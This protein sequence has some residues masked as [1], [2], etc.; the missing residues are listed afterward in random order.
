M[1][2]KQ[3]ERTVD[4][5]DDKLL[6]AG[7]L[8]S[9]C[10]PKS[11]TCWPMASSPLVLVLAARA[12]AHTSSFFL[13][14][15]LGWQ[16]ANKHSVP[17]RPLLHHDHFRVNQ[18]PLS[19]DPSAAEE[20]KQGRKRDQKGPCASSAGPINGP[21]APRQ[22]SQLATRGRCSARARQRAGCGTPSS[23][24]SSLAI[25][26]SNVGAVRSTSHQAIA[27]NVTRV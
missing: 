7:R 3:E 1:V 2:G 13:S 19:D 17:P 23:S 14:D 26:A 20:Q 22:L 18:V 12:R 9:R 15:S 16:R 8:S 6:L 5:G 11:A 27:A 10:G 21:K 24:L 4:R 25:N